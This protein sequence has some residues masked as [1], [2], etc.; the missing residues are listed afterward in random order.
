MLE[1][2][3]LQN[4]LRN[5]ESF[6]F[7]YQCMIFVKLEKW[8]KFFRNMLRFYFRNLL[9]FLN[10]C[11]WSCLRMSHW[12]QIFEHLLSL[13]FLFL[14]KFEIPLVCRISLYI[15]LIAIVLPASFINEWVVCGGL[16]FDNLETGHSNPRLRRLS[17]VLLHLI[18]NNK[19]NE[20]FIQ[21]HI[22]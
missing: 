4:I 21:K 1:I 9:I 20:V 7:W 19:N 8:L 3:W 14:T 10:T 2:C 5:H 17:I 16:F 13:R 15:T 11:F 6:K 18:I 12:S 22:R